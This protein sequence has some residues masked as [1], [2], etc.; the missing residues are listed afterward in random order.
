[1]SAAAIETW[2]AEQ[3]K[4]LR[5]DNSWLTVSGLFW[6]NEGDNTVGSGDDNDMVF[7]AGSCP[8][9]LGVFHRSGTTVTFTAAP[10]VAYTVN[11]AAPKAGALQVDGDG[12]YTPDTIEHGKLSFFVV[13]R[14]ERI[15][16]R[17]RDNDS[18]ARRDFTGRVWYPYDAAAVVP[19]TVT[20]PTENKTISI[21]NILGYYEDTPSAGTL[22]FTYQGQQLTLEA[23]D[24][25]GALFVIMRDKTSGHDTYGAGRFLMVPPPVDGKTVIDFNKAV[26]PPCAFTAY[27]TCPM[28]PPANHL[29]VTVAAG[30]KYVGEQH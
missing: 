17:L 24:G 20:P 2:R 6:L 8:A 5:A 1:M 9:R 29:P 27:A 26:S 4:S 3:E 28:A 11:G 22:H 13:T 19:A 12:K 21:Q 23:I 30:E 14:Q 16:I 7:P 25:K 10:G 15:G 18:Q